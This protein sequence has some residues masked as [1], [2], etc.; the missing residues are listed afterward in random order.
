MNLPG[1][2]RVPL[3]LLLLAGCASGPGSVPPPS[4]RATPSALPT[5]RTTV[6]PTLTAQPPDTGLPPNGA[7]ASGDAS[8]EGWLGSYCW[9]STCVDS[10]GPPPKATLPGLTTDDGQLS[11]SLSDGATFVRWTM[12]YGAESGEPLETLAQG[13]EAFDPDAQL[14]PELVELRSVDFE[15][16]P[17]G[18][19]LLV[20]FV[21]FPGGD[22]S[23]AWHVVMR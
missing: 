4:S 19:W 9:Q 11:F 7:L 20:A 8:V 10:A 15:S 23:Y 18:D 2:A 21:Q 22:L 14:Q 3:V 13:G 5:V 12:S 6:R 16:P 17:T 1:F